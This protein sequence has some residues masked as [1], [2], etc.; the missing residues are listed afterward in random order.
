MAVTKIGIEDTIG[1]AIGR[2]GEALGDALDK[3]VFRK[4]L[5]EKE[6]RGSP[7]VMQ[8][9][10]PG[11]R[12]AQKGGPDTLAAYAKGLDVNVEFID[13]IL[14]YTPTR[15]QAVDE[16][17]LTGGGAEKVAASAIAQSLFEGETA[18]A[19]LDAGLPAI[20]AAAT[21]SQ[22][23]FDAKN[24][25]VQLD[26]LE[27]QVEN[28]VIE[29]RLKTDA[30]T[31]RLGLETAQ[32][33]Q[34]FFNSF[35]QTTE[36]G[37]RMAMEFAFALNNPAFLTHIGLHEQMDFQA[38]LAL[39]NASS[40]FDPADKI[41]L[42]INLQD[43]WNTAVDRFKEAD[44]EGNDELLEIAVQDLN[45]VRLMIEEANQGNLI[46]PIDT[47][48][49]TLGKKFFGG[50]RAELAA[51]TFDNPK[52][53]EFA[54]EMDELG[55]TDVAQ[56]SL[57]DRNGNP[58]IDEE[59]KPTGEPSLLDYIRPPRLKEQ[60]IREFPTFL[61]SLT[62]LEVGSL[63]SIGAGSV[64]RAGL[65]AGLSGQTFTGSGINLISSIFTGLSEA[66]KSAI[67]ASAQSLTAAQ[68]RS[69]GN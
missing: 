23:T 58:L 49:A 10:V 66:L 33:T 45:S 47:S 14:A 27:F 17:F 42:S 5:K 44:D 3:T 41:Q 32:A 9:L 35:D 62:A 11:A 19:A 2:F 21:A 25:E 15:T 48:V 39:M 65:E 56:L 31:A 50:L 43:A 8:S 12:A 53:A 51:T 20:S 54:I 63:E 38:R 7:E 64:F 26:S 24:F 28:G 52:A 16:A 4:G 36:A 34:T 59:G 40:D 6:F 29:T 13:E 60:I 46:Y 67:N 22:G 68:R 61:E 55:I 57:I 69:R 37:R 30:I 1:G 18:Q